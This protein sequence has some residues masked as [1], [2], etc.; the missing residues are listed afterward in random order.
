MISYWASRF[1]GEVESIIHVGAVRAARY[2]SA[3][4]ALSLRHLGRFDRVVIGLLETTSPRTPDIH[5]LFQCQA[6]RT[7]SG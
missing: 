5:T 3:V 7:Q 6:T 2:T 1:D 4:G